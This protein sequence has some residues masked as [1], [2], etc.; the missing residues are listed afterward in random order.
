[1]ENY[2]KEDNIPEN[3]D[4]NLW[5]GTSPYKNYLENQYH[6]YNWRKMVGFGCG[7]LDMGVHIF[8]TPYNALELDVPSVINK[9]RK[10]MKLVFQKKIESLMY[11]PI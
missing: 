6:Q 2:P 7:T 1:M 3:L 4:W 10:L 8:D 11:S 9:C 5:L